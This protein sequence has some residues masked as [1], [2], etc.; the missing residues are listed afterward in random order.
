MVTFGSVPRSNRKDAS[1][2]KPCRFA[3]RL[4]F[5]GLK[6]ADSR[7]MALVFSLM[8]EPMPPN[9]PAIHLASDASQIIRSSAE[10]RSEERRVGKECVTTCRFRWSPYRTNKKLNITYINYRG[11]KSQL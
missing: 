10:S 6:Q 1:V 11:L 5:T 9:T 4:T 3:V 8:P 7:K 2:F